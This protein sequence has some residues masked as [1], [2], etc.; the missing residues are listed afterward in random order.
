MED[1]CLGCHYG[2]LRAWLVVVRSGFVFCHYL[3]NL[4]R[5]ANHGLCYRYDQRVS[6]SVGVVLVSLGMG[7]VLLLQGEQH[8]RLRED[9]VEYQLLNVL[10]LSEEYQRNLLQRLC[11]RP[12]NGDCPE[13]QLLKEGQCLGCRLGETAVF[14]SLF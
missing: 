1:L 14:L 12:S 9:L 8:V 6:C 13:H 2:V 7:Q 11:S 10:L 5:L 3:G 4:Y